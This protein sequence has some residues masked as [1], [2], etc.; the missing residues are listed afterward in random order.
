MGKKTFTCAKCTKQF[1][2][3]EEL[4]KS[5]ADSEGIA[6]SLILCSDC[7]RKAQEERTTKV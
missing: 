2:G 4:F 6:E 1:E 7:R 3:D 5:K